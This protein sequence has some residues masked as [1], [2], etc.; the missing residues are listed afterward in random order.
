[1][2]TNCCPCLFNASTSHVLNHV[3]CYA[4]GRLERELESLKADTSQ[5]QNDMEGQL[6]VLQVGVQPCVLTMCIT[7]CTVY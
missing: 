5:R 6:A 7:F 3:H 2:G 1:M 4:Q